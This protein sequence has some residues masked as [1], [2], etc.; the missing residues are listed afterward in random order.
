MALAESKAAKLMADDPAP[1]TTTPNPERKSGNRKL[2][3]QK[4]RRLWDGGEP[5]E[6][7]QEIVEF[8]GVAT[9]FALAVAAGEVKDLAR[10]EKF[11]RA[12]RKEAGVARAEDGAETRDQDIPPASASSPAPGTKVPLHHSG[13]NCDGVPM[14]TFRPGRPPDPRPLPPYKRLL[15]SH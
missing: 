11:L 5:E 1:S 10:V 9:R 13:R 14:M 4:V 15:P 8:K 7:D 6:P 12:P 3:G 2:Q